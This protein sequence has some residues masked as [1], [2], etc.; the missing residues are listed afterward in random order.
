MSYRDQWKMIHLLNTCKPGGLTI[1]E[2]GSL[3]INC[4]YDTIMELINDKIVESADPLKG[5]FTLH[6]IARR[7]L[8]DF[9]V[10]RGDR[11]KTFMQVDQP[12][13]FVIMPFSEDWSD[14]VYK[15]IFEPAIRDAKLE[16]I[17]GDE[18]DRVG[19]LTP[20]IFK[21]LQTVGVVLADITAPNPNVYYEL[22]VADTLGKEVFVLAQKGKENRIAADK[23]GVHYHTYDPTLPKQS[24]E[25]L[26]NALKQW[27]D[28]NSLLATPQ[29]CQIK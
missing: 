2:L 18:I 24:R 12:S 4:Y 20:G 13:C 16:C 15:N 9:I 1:P 29:F 17:R 10:C 8:N 6:P 21:T 19:Q 3:S 5:P 23:M 25:E 26:A 14:A 28:A 27:V 7:M 22:G 11:D